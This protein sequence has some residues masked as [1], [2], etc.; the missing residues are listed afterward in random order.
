MPGAVRKAVPS[1]SQRAPAPALLAVRYQAVARCG[2]RPDGSRNSGRHAATLRWRICLPPTPLEVSGLDGG[3]GGRAVVRKASGGCCAWRGRWSLAGRS[4]CWTRRGAARADRK[5]ASNIHLRPSLPTALGCLK[6]G[7]NQSMSRFMYI[8]PEDTED[9]DISRH[10]TRPTFYHND[11][12]LGKSS[13][14]NVR[15]EPS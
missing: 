12:W 15:T 7:E 14:I 9:R 11:G 1:T 5:S 4:S 13:T 10:I 6:C 8:A 3:A 2:H